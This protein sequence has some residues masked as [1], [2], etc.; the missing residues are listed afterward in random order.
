MTCDNLVIFCEHVTNALQTGNKCNCILFIN[1]N[2][3]TPMSYEV[4]TATIIYVRQICLS[5]VNVQAA[6]GSVKLSWQH[7]YIS[8]SMMTYKPSELGQTD[9]VFGF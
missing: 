1:Q 9:L 8:I 5:V 6:H 2:V 3:R 4:E 7:S